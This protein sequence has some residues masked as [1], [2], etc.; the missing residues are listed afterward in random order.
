[1]PINI[2]LVAIPDPEKSIIFPSFE[3]LLFYHNKKPDTST[4]SCIVVSGY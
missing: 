1:M 3:K 4:A 2:R